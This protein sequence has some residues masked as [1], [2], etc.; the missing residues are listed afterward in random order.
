MILFGLLFLHVLLLLLLLGYLGCV[1]HDFNQLLCMLVAQLD[2]RLLLILI[3]LHGS[4][5][6]WLTSA[7][8]C[9]HGEGAA[10]RVVHISD[11]IVDLYIESRFVELELL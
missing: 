1:L 4:L 2:R 8:L 11:I 9:D 7:C 10:I 6:G 5:A 3:L